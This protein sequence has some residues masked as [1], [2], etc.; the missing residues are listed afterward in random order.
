M[1]HVCIFLLRMALSIQENLGQH[2]FGRFGK[3]ISSSGVFQMPTCG[4]MEAKP[5]LSVGNNLQS[6]RGP[7]STWLIGRS[8][9]LH[10]DSQLVMPH[11]ERCDVESHGRRLVVDRAYEFPI[12]RDACASRYAVQQQVNSFMC[13]QI[14][15]AIK[16][17]CEQGAASEIAQKSLPVCRKFHCSG[18]RQR[19]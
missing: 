9:P 8:I 11:E 19:P 17:A 12:Q 2:G 16:S 7:Q 4:Q 14:G 15:R 1:S 3:N 6:D 10:L 5:S 18:S 13:I